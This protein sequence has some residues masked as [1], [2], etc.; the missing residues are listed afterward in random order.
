MFKLYL[1]WRYPGYM[2]SRQHKIDRS[3]NGRQRVSW[4]VK[5]KRAFSVLFSLI[6][7]RVMCIVCVSL[8]TDGYTV[9]DL[10]FFWILWKYLCSGWLHCITSKKEKKRKKD[11]TPHQ[12]LTLPKRR[13]NC[14]C[15]VL[16]WLSLL[17][18]L[19]SDVAL[20]YQWLFSFPKFVKVFN[21]VCQPSPKP[22]NW[23]LNL[24]LP[25]RLSL[26]NGLKKKKKAE[27]NIKKKKQRII[28]SLEI[29]VPCDGE[30]K[31]VYLDNCKICNFP[32]S[33]GTQFF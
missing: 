23:W 2:W 9:T 15:W 6:H 32:S 7:C 27:R 26:D 3:V 29:L 16:L 13:E 22:A 14:R 8:T 28:R 20:F 12:I 21:N 25:W 30:R 5:K 19:I 4:N 24:P 11:R 17:L 33:M 18:I 10:F 31:K 1:Y